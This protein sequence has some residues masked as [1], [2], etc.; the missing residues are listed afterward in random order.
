MSELRFLEQMQPHNSRPIQ[1]RHFPDVVLEPYRGARDLGTVVISDGL[2]SGSWLEILDAYSKDNAGL[3]ERLDVGPPPLDLM[4]IESPNGAFR[5]TKVSDERGE[6]G[7]LLRYRTDYFQSPEFA[8]WHQGPS[9]QVSV[10]DGDAR[11]DFNDDDDRGLVKEKFA[12]YAEYREDLNWVEDTSMLSGAMLI[13]VFKVCEFMNCQNIEL[14]EAPDPRPKRVRKRAQKRGI[15]YKT[16]AIRRTKKLYPLSDLGHTREERRKHIV[17]GHFKTYTEESPLFGKVVGRYF[18][19]QHVRGS[20]E[21]GEI[22]KTYKL[23]EAS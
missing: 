5:I 6:A 18:W 11:W 7:R 20:D 1:S 22:H 13:F 15:E 4:T 16:L 10:S 19:A 14:V 23:E 2:V 12:L 8:Y 17:R 9:F 21:F 3:R